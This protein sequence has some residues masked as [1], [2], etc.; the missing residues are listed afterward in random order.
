[1]SDQ[2]DKKPA[3]ESQPQQQPQPQDKP[4][5]SDKSKTSVT[6]TNIILD[7]LFTKG[8]Y[9]E[10]I[11]LTGGRKCILRTRATKMSLDITSRLEDKDIKSAAKYNQ[12]FSLYCLAGSLYSM[13]GK[14]LPDD[15]DKKV[16]VISEL[17]APITD[18]LVRKLIGF[19]K[20]V[21]G[22]YTI[23]EVKN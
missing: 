23:E 1:M 21:S 8:Y 6:Q 15:F 22:T 7:S 2:H 12:M 19:D 11:V 5:P 14:P 17:P 20:T 13:G 10:E 9:E 18:M 4:Q 3:A 16:E